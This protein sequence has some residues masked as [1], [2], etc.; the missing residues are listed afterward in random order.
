M[1]LIDEAIVYF[2]LFFS[3]WS[4]LFLP[5]MSLTCIHFWNNAAAL[6]ILA[7]HLIASITFCCI[8]C[9]A[10]LTNTVVFLVGAIIM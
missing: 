9:R 1:T 6:C 7:H 2:S 10:Q 4:N 5:L 8:F 3:F